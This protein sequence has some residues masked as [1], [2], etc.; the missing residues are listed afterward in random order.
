MTSAMPTWG[1]ISAAPETGTIVTSPSS[2]GGSARSFH[3]DLTPYL[4]D[5]GKKLQTKLQKAP[6]T[7]VLGQY[8]GLTWKKLAKPRYSTPEKVPV[9]VKIANKLIMGQHKAPTS[10]MFIG[11]GT[12]GII[13]GTKNS[14]EYGAGDGVMVAGDVRS[15]ARKYCGKGVTVKYQQYPLSHFTAVAQWLPA[16]YAWMLDRYAGKTAPS[17]CGSIKPGNPLTPLKVQK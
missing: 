9:F 6:I 7:A 16:A 17:S 12:G 11:Q 15:L 8:P 10:P 4:S 13:E 5:Y 2:R 14:K 1:A 3:V